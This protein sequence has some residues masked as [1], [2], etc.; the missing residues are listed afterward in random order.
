MDPGSHQGPGSN[1]AS[2]RPSGWQAFRASYLWIPVACY[3]AILLVRGT[4]VVEGE[5]TTELATARAPALDV[6]RTEGLI[7]VPAG[8]RLAAVHRAKLTAYEPSRLSCGEFAD[9]VTST[10]RNAMVPDGVAVAPEVIPYGSLL[11]IPGIGFRRADDTGGAMVT[12]WRRRR[13]V[14]VDIRMRTIPECREWGVKENVPVHVFVP[15]E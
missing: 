12:A 4:I 15:V 6:P 5:E 13:Q 9:G 8:Y 1:R 14:H 3:V 2:V 7:P 10:G 11:F